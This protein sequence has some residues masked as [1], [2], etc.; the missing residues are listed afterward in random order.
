MTDDESEQLADMLWTMIEN[1]DLSDMENC[2]QFFEITYSF[3]TERGIS[4]GQEVDT[5]EQQNDNQ[6]NVETD[7]FQE[8]VENN[9]AW[10][11]DM[12]VM[13]DAMETKCTL[14]ELI[15]DIQVEPFDKYSYQSG[16]NK[17]LF[18]ATFGDFTGELHYSDAEEI[19]FYLETDEPITE[20]DVIEI[21]NSVPLTNMVDNNQVFVWN[22]KLEMNVYYHNYCTA[23]YFRLCSNSI[24]TEEDIGLSEENTS[25]EWDVYLE[26]I[27]E[28]FYNDYT[29]EQIKNKYP[30]GILTEV[31]DY[32]LEYYGYVGDYK[33]YYSYCSGCPVYGIGDEN[34]EYANFSWTSESGTWCSNEYLCEEWGLTYV[35][36]GYMHCNGAPVTIYDWNE[37]LVVIVLQAEDSHTLIQILPMANYRINYW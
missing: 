27:Y 10:E 19:S 28:M 13:F 23:I 4:Y 14:D 5:E 17:G 34:S 6:N 30:T 31:A 12:N 1:E 29:F 37:K 35:D 25:G 18:Y 9:T 16:G 20:N 7:N 26:D 36:S 24:G 3:I 21:F 15:A 32:L 11:M 22:D 8:S 2:E 33:G